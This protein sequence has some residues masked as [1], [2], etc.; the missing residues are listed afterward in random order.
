MT[1]KLY[2]LVGAG[3]FYLIGDEDIASVMTCVDPLRQEMCDP[4]FNEIRSFSNR[5]SFYVA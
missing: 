2:G 3:F 5:H 1:C 4:L